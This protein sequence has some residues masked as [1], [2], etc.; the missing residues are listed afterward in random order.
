MD[1]VMIKWVSEKHSRE[2]D[3]GR[4]TGLYILDNYKVDDNF[5]THHLKRLV[6]FFIYF[7]KEI[8]IQFCDFDNIS[9][10]LLDICVQLFP[11]DDDSNVMH[12]QLCVYQMWGEKSM[13]QDLNLVYTNT[14]VHSIVIAIVIRI[15]FKTS[16]T[17][18]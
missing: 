11:L 8:Q 17:F 6:Y 4:A 7:F 16:F 3:G 10:H 9:S 1:K 13:W 18:K 12:F 2:A 5:P 15:P 14:S